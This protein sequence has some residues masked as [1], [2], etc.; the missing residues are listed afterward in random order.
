[1]DETEPQLAFVAYEMTKKGSQKIIKD[2]MQKSIVRARRE[3]PELLGYTTVTPFRFID[4]VEER[5]S[6]LIQA[7]LEE[8]GN[9]SDL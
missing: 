8:I 7:G 2:E 4:Q 5:S 3:M 1:M 6:L 9:S